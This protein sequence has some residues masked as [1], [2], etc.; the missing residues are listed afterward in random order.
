MSWSCAQLEKDTGK[1]EAAARVA[2][3]NCL[4]WAKAT[5]KALQ[6]YEKNPN[7][8]SA[9][10]PVSKVASA[11]KDA[12]DEM[13]A[14]CR[15][16]EAVLNLHRSNMEYEEKEFRKRLW[17]AEDEPDA[18]KARIL[19]EAQDLKRAC[20]TVRDYLVASYELLTHLQEVEAMV[21]DFIRSLRSEGFYVK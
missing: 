9:K 16:W 15:G 11:L 7:A 6:E 18:V 19:K 21:D 3:V 5:R 4:V 13:A 1:W 8:S 17:S 12:A 14:N 10:L 2:G 20:P